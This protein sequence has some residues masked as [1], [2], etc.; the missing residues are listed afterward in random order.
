MIKIGTTF[1]GIGAIEHAFER[2]KIKH[3][4]VFACDNGGIELFS[5]KII[6]RFNDIS[7]EIS[8]INNHINKL[9]LNNSDNYK[10][11]LL[12]ELNKIEKNYNEIMIQTSSLKCL[13]KIKQIV[14]HVMLKLKENNDSKFKEF[15]NLELDTSDYLYL[16]TELKNHVKNDKKNFSEL[17]LISKDKDYRAVR[18]DIKEITK[19][20]SQL[21]ESILTLEVLDKLSNLKSKKEKKDFIDSLYN[22]KENFVKKSYLA[23]YILDEENFHQNISFLDGS[24]YKDKIDLYVGGSPCQ[25]FSIVGKRGGFEDTR[26]TLFYEYVRILK[27]T[28][29]RFFIYENVKGVLSHDNGQTW[30]TMQNSFHDTGYK[31]KHYILNSKNFGIPQ[32]RERLFVIGFKNT[33]DFDKFEDPKAINLKYKLQDF[34]EDNI[35]DKYYLPE[36]GIKF[37]TDN[38]NLNKKYTQINGDIALCQKANQQFNWHGDFIECYTEDELTNMSKIDK[39][40]FLSENVKKY[41]LDDKFFMNN[42]DS[43]KLIDLD[44]ARPLTATMHKMHRAGVDNYVSYGKSL[45]P[46]LRRIRKLTPRECL[47]LMGFC[48]SFKIDVSDTQLYK[49]AGNSIVVDVLISI[50]EQIKKIY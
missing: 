50:L 26:G 10:K 43:D 23:N 27:E 38:K 20:L 5:K 8:F 35:D 40:Y 28:N 11:K 37:V 3:K 13:E 46:E 17:D 31:F 19:K 39:K 18:R 24:Y 44:V 16:V 12:L 7:S 29:P 47:R 22:K 6:D 32:H 21:H 15:Y 30:E 33:K 41:I 49:Q 34:L 25:S 14:S 2:M 1:S 4:I 48:D 42:K 9:K 45:K 36:K